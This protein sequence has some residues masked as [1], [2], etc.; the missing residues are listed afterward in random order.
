MSERLIPLNYYGEEFKTEQAKVE[1][2]VSNV[3]YDL[4]TRLELDKIAQKL[5][6]VTMHS[7]VAQI[8]QENC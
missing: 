5:G 7:L 1:E 2:E 6:F 8:E 4:S 3:E